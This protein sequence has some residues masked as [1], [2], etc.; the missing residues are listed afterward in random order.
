[1][2]IPPDQ[3]VEKLKRVME[4]LQWEWDRRK[5]LHCK[6]RKSNKTGIQSSQLSALVALLIKKGIIK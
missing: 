4:E 2:F 1:M 5:E 3:L 6:Q